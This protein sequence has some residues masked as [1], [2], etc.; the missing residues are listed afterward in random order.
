MFQSLALV[1]CTHYLLHNPTKKSKGVV[2][3]D[4]GSHGVKPLLPIHCF[5][6]V[7]FKKSQ[8]I[9]PMHGGDHLAE[10]KPT[11]ET[12]LIEKQCYV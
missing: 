3:G 4:L 2:S 6:K 9:K 11:A 10:T 5:G 12:L 7:A 8:T 1:F